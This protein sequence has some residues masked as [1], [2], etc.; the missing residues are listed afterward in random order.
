MNAKDC[1][2]S[3]CFRKQWAWWAQSALTK[4][5]NIS[6][7]ATTKNGIPRNEAAILHKEVNVLYEDLQGNPNC[8]NK[9]IKRRDLRETHDFNKIS[10]EQTLQA[11]KITSHED[12]QL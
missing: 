11:M 5:K 2:Q 3:H 1:H 12:Y 8:L 7:V 9:G 10:P 4:K 6:A